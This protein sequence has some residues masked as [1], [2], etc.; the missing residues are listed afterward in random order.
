MLT[1]VFPKKCGPPGDPAAGTAASSSRAVS[2]TSATTRA[3]RGRTPGAGGGCSV[4]SAGSASR[5]RPRQGSRA[6]TTGK[7]W[8]GRYDRGLG[9]KGCRR[10]R[11]RGGGGQA[12][13]SSM[14]VLCCAMRCVLA[15]G[16]TYCSDLRRPPTCP[17]TCQ[18]SYIS[19]TS[20]QL[21]QRLIDL[22]KKYKKR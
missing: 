21:L 5:T 3:W 10:G 20:G 17:P 11:G 22:S 2:T 4:P 18:W 8:P 14:L 12:G 7:V 19:D 16:L 9:W 13:W 1:L 15:R 6:S